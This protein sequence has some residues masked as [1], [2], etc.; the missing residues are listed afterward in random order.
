MNAI[1]G[2]LRRLIED[3]Q[4]VLLL[5]ILLAATVSLVLLGDMVA[6]AI[7]ALIIAFL[8][9]GAVAWLTRRGVTHWVAVTLVFLTFI[10]VATLIVIAVI[11]PVVRQVAAFIE[12]SPA[13]LA[14][15]RDGLLSLQVRFPDLITQVQVDGWI[16][17]ITDEVALLGPRLLEYSVSGITGALTVVVYAVLVPLMV[18]FFLKDKEQILSWAAGFLPAEK[19]LVEKVW[20]EAVQKAGD[21]ARGKVY[22]IIIFGIVAYISYEI[23]GLRYAALLAL[24]TG[25]SVLIPYIGAAATTLP[26]ALV[27]YF[28]WGWSSDL[29]TAVVVYAILQALDGNLLAPL[30][31]SEVMKLHPNAIIIAILVFGGIWGF[32]GV[33]FAIPLATLANAVIRAWRDSVRGE[34]KENT[35]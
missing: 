30:L 26:I 21:Y 6:P 16:A 10:F 12:D 2:W 35:D 15:V 14:G 13:I 32:W 4:L 5:L 8:L 18:F 3:P 24:I 23:I 1:T 19:P 11:P 7:A 22:E 27:A 20:M 29:A 28:Q 33:F 17:R 31:F 9:D 34:D 25:L